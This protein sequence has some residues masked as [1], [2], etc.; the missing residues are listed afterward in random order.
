LYIILT[1]Q[2]KGDDNM[3][4]N[5][6]ELILAT[7]VIE[8]FT[9]VRSEFESICKGAGIKGYVGGLTKPMYFIKQSDSEAFINEV[10]RVTSRKFRNLVEVG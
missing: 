1:K 10:E 6:N 3:G 2:T 4:I 8:K 5:I 7:K 9:R